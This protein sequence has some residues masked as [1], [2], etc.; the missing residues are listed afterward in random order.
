MSCIT[1]SGNRN[2]ELDA[3][4]ISNIG[5]AKKVII[6]G[7]NTIK[8]E[9]F[10]GNCY[11]ETINL[12]STLTCIGYGAFKD[13]KNLKRIIIPSSVQHI[14][15]HVFHNCTS[16]TSVIFEIGSHLQSIGDGDT[17]DIYL[18]SGLSTFSAPPSVLNI[19]RIEDV[20]TAQTI[21]GKSG[22][23]VTATGD[24]LFPNG[25]IDITADIKLYK[26]YTLSSSNYYFEIKSNNV[27]FD[28]N[29]KT[30]TLDNIE[31]FEGLIK[32]STFSYVTIKNLTILVKCDTML[33]QDR[34][35]RT[36]K[37]GNSFLCKQYFAFSA[38]GTTENKIENCKIKNGY[39][40]N[41]NCGGILGQYTKI[42]KVIDCEYEGNIE[43]YLHKKEGKNSTEMDSQ[44]SAG[45]AA[46]YL[47]NECV[48][49]RCKFVGDLIGTKQGGGIIAGHPEKCIMED[50]VFEGSI[51]RSNASDHNNKIEKSI[52]TDSINVA[53][54]N[55]TDG[56]YNNIAVETKTEE[57][58]G[59]RVKVI[60]LNK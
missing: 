33:S 23:K 13:C 18:G 44:G 6:I 48:F 55:L 9:T 45:I 26:D 20:E 54:Y 31:E 60:V 41:K 37:Q 52:I 24:A 59:W 3:S 34:S 14:D 42:S 50:C 49:K 25:N 10:Q 21:S 30:I 46:N 7:Y 51:K 57:G 27:T 39:I 36:V 29:G 19:F 15:R 28:G 38:Q 2:E 8:S 5:N 16:L 47:R 17:D 56:A 53:N 12:P 43:T 40:N 4:T 11:V 35:K 32:N 58:Y 22:V 1:Y